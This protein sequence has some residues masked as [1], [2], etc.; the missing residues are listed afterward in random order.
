MKLH[1]FCVIPSELFFKTERSEIPKLHFLFLQ[2]QAIGEI[3]IVPNWYLRTL[4][5]FFL[6]CTRNCKK[7]VWNCKKMRS[8]LHN[9]RNKKKLKNL[10]WC[11]WWVSLNWT[12]WGKCILR[13][14]AS[15]CYYQYLDGASTFANH[16]TK[17]Y[18]SL[19]PI[20]ESWFG[21]FA[22]MLLLNKFDNLHRQ[23]NCHN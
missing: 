4:R 14:V 5:Y 2:F 21:V 13:W 16:Q 10:P 6:K 22:V 3:P 8:E 9:A 18:Q 20:L 1:Y 17:H 7:C 23:F 11:R 12:P 15:S 19:G